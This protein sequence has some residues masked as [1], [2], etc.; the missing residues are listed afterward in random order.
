IRLVSIVAP[1]T[2]AAL[3]VSTTAAFFF[4]WGLMRMGRE[5]LPEEGR[6]RAVMVVCAW[7][8]SFILFAGYAESLTLA[9]IVWALIL[10]RASRWWLATLLGVLAGLSRPSGVLVAVPLLILALRS[11]RL[12]SVAVLLTPAGALSYLGWLHATG[13]LPVVVAY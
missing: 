8:E 6:L 10:A 9:L 4:F 7:P 13:R 1:P 5:L 12:A 2:V 11:R 3:L